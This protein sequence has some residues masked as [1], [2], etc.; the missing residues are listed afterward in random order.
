[1]P[2]QMFKLQM[3]L[4]YANIEQNAVSCCVVD[5][6]DSFNLVGMQITLL[7]SYSINNGRPSPYA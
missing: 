7:L 2:Q 4:N 5:G 6:H 3:F 1:M